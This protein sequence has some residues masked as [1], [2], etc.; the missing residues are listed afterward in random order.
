MK[1]LIITMFI[2]GVCVVAYSIYFKIS[3]SSSAEHQ[4]VETTSDVVPVA[5]EV[6]DTG[7]VE[8]PIE[9]TLTTEPPIPASIRERIEMTAADSDSDGLAKQ[10][11]VSERQTEAG[12]DFE[13][14]NR[15]D[16]NAAQLLSALKNELT[17]LRTPTTSSRPDGDAD[18]LEDV[19]G[20]DVENAEET[21]QPADFSSLLLETKNAL[22]KYRNTSLDRPK[23]VPLDRSEA[24]AALK[25]RASVRQNE[26]GQV[27]G[28]T[29]VHYETRV[30]DETF[31][32]L[33]PLRYL[34][35][36]TVSGGDV[37]DEGLQHIKDLQNLKRLAL[38]NTRISAWGLG[39]HLGGLKQLESLNVSGSD[40]TDE[41]LLTWEEFDR[42]KH[43]DLSNTGITDTG[44][45]ALTT[46][47]RLE[48]LNLSGD[49]DHGTWP[50]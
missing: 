44:L 2:V 49:P 5:D 4:A 19:L 7:L 22:T 50:G 28:I 42:L 23:A 27:T 8:S 36:L 35:D 10:V 45:Y 16:G 21:L 11:A 18:V 38:I 25:R 1:R 34:E 47:T 41:G 12:H 30:T 33:K 43:L 31:E 32:L 6:P 15:P 13:S 9:S 24:I 17:E 29:F 14:F 37:T 40:I 20:A 26:Q 3:A 48:A 39:R 46:W